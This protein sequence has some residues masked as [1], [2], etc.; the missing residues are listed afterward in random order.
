LFSRLEGLKF[1][2]LLNYDQK[3]FRIDN[4]KNIL[5]IDIDNQ[6]ELEQLRFTML[7]NLNVKL[8]IIFLWFLN[9]YLHIRIAK[10]I[11]MWFKSEN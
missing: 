7:P 1:L 8:T 4:K 10:S 9:F 2:N 3:S 6:Q 11:L 5:K